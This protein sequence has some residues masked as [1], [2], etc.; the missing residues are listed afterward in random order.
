V[1]FF[2]IFGVFRP[3]AA[4]S[5]CRP[6]RP[7]PRRYATAQSQMQASWHV[8]VAW[9]NWF[10]LAGDAQAK[11]SIA[12]IYLN[13]ERMDSVHLSVRDSLSL[14][15]TFT[16]AWRVLIFFPYTLRACTFCIYSAYSIYFVLIRF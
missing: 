2:L 3:F 4:P 12:Q 1:N 16:A 6:V 5:K 14:W 15:E 10:S 8:P 9:L 13:G 7:A 11:L